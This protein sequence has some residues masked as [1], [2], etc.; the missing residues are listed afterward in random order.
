M[1]LRGKEMTKERDLT[2]DIGSERDYIRLDMHVHSHYSRDSV[3]PLE[4]IVQVWRNR[5]IFSVVCDHD[6]IEGSRQFCAQIHALDPDA[7][8]VLAEEITTAD[9]ELIGLFLSEEVRPGLSAEE[10]VDLIHGQGGLVLVPHPFCRYRSR[11]I[12]SEALMRIVD[13]VDIVE[14]YNARNVVD[15]DNDAAIAF[16]DAHA[17]PISVG[18]DAHIPMELAK[19]WIEVPL[20]Q[21]SEELIHH[22]KGA[23]V[24]FRRSNNTVHLFTKMVKIVRKHMR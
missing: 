4:N 3:I 24:C 18:S 13:R 5:R 1:E 14:G 2:I 8:F 22:M 11:A 15:E 7:P 17:K 19:V 12:K 23:K 9:G 10:T 21:T 6:T 16:A 20:F